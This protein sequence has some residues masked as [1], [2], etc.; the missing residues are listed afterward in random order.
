ME[1]VRINKKV[2]TTLCLFYIWNIY[3][4]LFF[5]DSALEFYGMKRNRIGHRF[6]ILYYHRIHYI[7]LLQKALYIDYSSNIGSIVDSRDTL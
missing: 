1:E 3:S 5:L 7:F 4:F 2:Y 6:V